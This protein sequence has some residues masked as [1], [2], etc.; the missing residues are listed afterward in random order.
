MKVRPSALQALTTTFGRKCAKPKL[1]RPL[2]LLLKTK[3]LLR[4]KPGATS[5]SC[6][7]VYRAPRPVQL[8]PPVEE[9]APLVREPLSSSL[10]ASLEALLELS[11]F[12]ESVA[13]PSGYDARTARLR[14]SEG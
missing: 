10:P 7:Q 11:D 6:S 5:S 14:L 3:Q 2:R 1:R 8:E 4:G 9:E 12:G 13:W